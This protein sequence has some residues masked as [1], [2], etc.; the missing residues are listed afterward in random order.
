MLQLNFLP[1]PIIRTERL[2][3]R[4]VGPAD[5]KQ[6]HFL[7][8]DSMVLSYI[9]KTPSQ[10]LEESAGFI[11]KINAQEK[12]GECITWGITRKDNPWLI[13]SI[14]FW[15]IDPVRDRAEVGYSL[16]PAF[17]NQ[18]LMNET[19]GKIVEYGFETMKLE[20]IEAY[21]NEKNLASRRL[22][23]KNRFT[24]DAAL[25]LEKLGKEEPADA[26]IYTL[27]R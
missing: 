25:E 7:R 18:G 4:H 16:H 2:V 14:C 1:F 21:T 6:I 5:L 13:G 22:L 19:L 23:E 17:H 11:E 9:N 8:S 15:N 12:K 10:S 20:A 26:T 3:L 27:Y 24:R